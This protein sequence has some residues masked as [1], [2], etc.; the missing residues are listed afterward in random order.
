MTCWAELRY[1]I[2]N[3]GSGRPESAAGGSD[4]SQLSEFERDRRDL[5]IV[6]GAEASI[7][8][9]VGNTGNYDLDE[10]GRKFEL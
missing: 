9:G 10:D 8:T 1:E 2:A 4:F 3:V 5:L 6:E 7:G